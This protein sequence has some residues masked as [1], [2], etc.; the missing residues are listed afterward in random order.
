MVRLLDYHGGDKAELL[1][2][3]RQL[4]CPTGFVNPSALGG[5][6]AF[7]EGSGWCTTLFSIAP[8]KAA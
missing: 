1:G 6:H 8:S 4:W 5:D 2:L 3:P 7:S